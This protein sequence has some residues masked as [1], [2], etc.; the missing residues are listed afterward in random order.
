MAILASPDFYIAC[1]ACGD[2]AGTF[3][4]GDHMVAAQSVSSVN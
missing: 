3:G 4:I 1:K 2:G